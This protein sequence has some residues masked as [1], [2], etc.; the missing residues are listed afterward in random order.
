MY[1]VQQLVKGM[2]GAFLPAWRA[3]WPSDRLLLLRT[4]DYKAAPGPHVAAV[5]D[6]LGML[7]F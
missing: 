2:Y 7:T 1:S 6:F 3:V 4:E 5:S